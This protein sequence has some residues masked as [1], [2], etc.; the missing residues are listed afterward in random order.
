MSSYFGE[1]SPNNWANSN[2]E[3]HFEQNPKYGVNYSDN[4]YCQFAPA[5]SFSSRCPQNYGRLDA[6]SIPA[7]TPLYDQSPGEYDMIHTFCSGLVSS[8][9]D[10][11]SLPVENRNFSS[12]KLTTFPSPGNPAFET[13][14]TVTNQSYDG[15]V[16]ESSN[17]TYAGLKTNI[18]PWMKSYKDSGQAS[19]RTRQTYTR[20]QTLELEKEFHFNRYLT[21]RRRIEIAHTLGLTE[22]QVKIWFQNRRMKAKKENKLQVFEDQESSNLQ[23]ENEA[24][25]GSLHKNDT[26]VAT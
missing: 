14:S 12:C 22:R 15:R 19:K 13:S 16:P 4:H 9:S 5:I 21:R 6:L 20:Y 11:N 26:N 1:F 23:P 3:H 24:K 17:T 2:Q 25:S 8:R 10:Q 7:K 18:Y